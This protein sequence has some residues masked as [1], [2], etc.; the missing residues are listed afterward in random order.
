MTDLRALALAAT[1]GPWFE[2]DWND[3]DGQ[4]KTTIERRTPEVLRPGW[5]SIW[6]DAMVHH[7]VA[8]TEAGENPLADAAYIA[9]CSPDRIL[10]LLDVVEAAQWFVNGIAATAG[11]NPQFDALCAALAALAALDG[12]EPKT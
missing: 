3:D 9:A 10:A 4:V 5:A 12:K 8:E 1:P 6:P 11:D 2:A 7:R